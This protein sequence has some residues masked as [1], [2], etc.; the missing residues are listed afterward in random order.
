M[1]REPS[2]YDDSG[3]EGRIGGRL[4][5]LDRFINNFFN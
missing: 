2:I 5:K 1:A 4:A 3:G